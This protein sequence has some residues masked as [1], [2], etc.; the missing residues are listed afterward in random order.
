MLQPRNRW[1]LSNRW[2]LLLPLLTCL[3][4][5]GVLSI[6]LVALAMLTEPARSRP[7]P[8]EAI[9]RVRRILDRPAYV[10][11]TAQGG[12]TDDERTGG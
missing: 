3:G 6:V 2:P 7:A 1:Q 8:T 9:V 5:Q 4:I 10:A 12:K 11:D